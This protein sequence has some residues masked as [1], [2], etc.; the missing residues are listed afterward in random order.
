MSPDG[1]RSRL[2][3]GKKRQGIA[4]SLI[5]KSGFP[6]II[7]CCLVRAPFCILVS[8]LWRLDHQRDDIRNREKGVWELLRKSHIGERVKG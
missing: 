7:D 8:K 1:S 3:T 4:G 5:Q 6:G 2:T